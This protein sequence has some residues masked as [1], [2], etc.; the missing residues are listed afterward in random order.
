MGEGKWDGM[1]LGRGGCD[2]EGC[3]AAGWTPD[4]AVMMKREAERNKLESVVWTRVDR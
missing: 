1:R 4:R 3:S 2:E